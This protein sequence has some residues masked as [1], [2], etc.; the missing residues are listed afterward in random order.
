M[1]T[2]IFAQLCT[3]VNPFER[4]SSNRF[5]EI[6]GRLQEIWHLAEFHAVR[7]P[8]ITALNRAGVGIEAID[9]AK[10]FSKNNQIRALHIAGEIA[11]LSNALAAEHIDHLF[12]KG[13]MLGVQVFGGP[14]QRE[15]NDID[16]LVSPAKRDKAIAILR[17][18]DYYPMVSDSNMRQA[19]FDYMG[20]HALKHS[21]SGIAVDL[22]WSLV[23][24]LP[25]PIRT[26]TIMRSREQLELAGIAIPVPSVMD[27]GL[28]LA[29]H[30][31][32]EGWASFEW[33]LD[34]AT[35][36]AKHQRFDW[37]QA[38]A[39]SQSRHCS[40]P[41]LIAVMLAKRHFG[42]VIDHA[43]LAIAE[44]DRTIREDVE[45]IWERHA[46]CVERQ[47]SDE[48]FGSLRLCESPRQRAMISLGY[49]TTRTIGDFEALPLPRQMWWAYRIFRPFRLAW[50]WIVRSRFG[51][52]IRF[53]Q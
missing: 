12:M 13:A 5:L 30:G 18:Y 11:Q 49:L 44:Q 28:L 47:Y 26:E 31:Q 48:V 34:F 2:Q 8:L 25:F 36:A 6:E 16:L 32:K 24:D 22:H 42:K 20:Q 3:V 37:T 33:V 29:G 21:R 10:L 40:R 35:F 7:P 43:I 45:L 53:H 46:H 39:R 19:F 14:E 51:R 1:D 50:Q 23:G 17:T 15:Y 38:L 9:A 27:L 4:M 52:A 41:L